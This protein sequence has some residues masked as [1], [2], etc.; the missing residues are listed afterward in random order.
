MADR[1][2]GLGAAPSGNIGDG[3]GAPALTAS[4]VVPEPPPS[5]ADADQLGTM[6]ETISVI[7]ALVTFILAGL[8]PVLFERL[9]ALNETRLAYNRDREIDMLLRYVQTYYAKYR[10]DSFEESYASPH[11]DDRMKTAER[12]LVALSRDVRS[13]LTI[14]ADTIEVVT[15]LLELQ[16]RDRERVMTAA[17]FFDD[18]LIVSPQEE[19]SGYLRVYLRKLLE[20]GYFEDEECVREVRKLINIVRRAPE[21][22]ELWLTAEQGLEPRWVPVAWQA[23]L[24]FLAGLGLLYLVRLIVFG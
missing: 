11:G 16:S 23:S 7:V 6:L 24:A 13:T 19:W 12:R 8:V 22:V 4:T 15:P 9:R 18:L 20:Y 5:A 17:T 1:D 14:H 10:F 21:P 2:T 3:S